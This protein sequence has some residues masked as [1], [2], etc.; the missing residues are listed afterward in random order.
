MG[1]GTIKSSKEVPYKLNIQKP[2]GPT[3]PH[4]ALDPEKIRIH[5]DLCTL[6]FRAAPLTTAKN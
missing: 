4:L 6:V 2:C 1:A 3:I 5:N